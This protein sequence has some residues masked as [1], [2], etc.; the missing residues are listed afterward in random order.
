MTIIAMLLPVL[1]VMTSLIER[2]CRPFSVVVDTHTKIPRFCHGIVRRMTTFSVRLI[3]LG[4]GEAGDHSELA[5]NR[6]GLSRLTKIVLCPCCGI[7]A[8][9]VGGEW[10][11]DSGAGKKAQSQWK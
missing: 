5:G 11:K 9:E 2:S 4:F 8:I 6:G 3:L 1:L 10:G 7:T